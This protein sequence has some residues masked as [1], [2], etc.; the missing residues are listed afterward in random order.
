MAT[1][2]DIERTLDSL[3]QSMVEGDKRRAEADRA[4]AE[5]RAKTE[6]ALAESRSE[7]ERAMKEL[8]VAQKKTESA[9]E[10]LSAQVGGVNNSIGEI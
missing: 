6:R 4:L 10:K 3:A 2:A 5:Y 1:I 9:L 7:T 8:A